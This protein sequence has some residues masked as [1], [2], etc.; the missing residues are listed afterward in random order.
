MPIPK[1]GGDITRVLAVLHSALHTSFPD[2]AH[3]PHHLCISVR[4]IGQPASGGG[5]IREEVQQVRRFLHS[6]AA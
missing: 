4:S 5:L 1:I 6:S 2:P 3:R